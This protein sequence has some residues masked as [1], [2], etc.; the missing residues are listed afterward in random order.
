MNRTLARWSIAAALLF[1]ASVILWFSQKTDA[2]GLQERSPGGAELPGPTAGAQTATTTP[3][4]IP[5][6]LPPP[7]TVLPIA[8]ELATALVRKDD[9]AA[10]LQA[11]EQLLFFYKQGFGE[12]PVGQ[13]E[14]IVAALLGENSKRAAYLP[15]DCPAIKDGK[16]LDPWGTPYWFHPVSRKQMEIRSAGPDRELFTSD[17]LTGN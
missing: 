9:P 14:D 15:P 13:N 11:V 16:L 2:P 17:D 8:S 3:A 5:E 1:L 12:N 7:V 4:T 10:S 6:P